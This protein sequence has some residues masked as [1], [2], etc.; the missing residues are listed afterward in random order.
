[1]ADCAACGLPLDPAARYC[2]HCGAGVTEAGGLR[3]YALPGTDDRDL[4]P[5]G[6]PA[7]GGPAQ[8]GRAQGGRAQ[9]GPAQGGRV[10]EAPREPDEPRGRRGLVMV[11][12][13]VVVA[14]VAVTAAT[15][16]VATRRH[17]RPAAVPGTAA[18]VGGG[19]AV[20]PTAAA[21][22]STGAPVLLADS[23]RRSPYAPNV[24]GLFRQYFEAINGRDYDAWLGTLS[25][26]RRPDPRQ[27][28]L[29]EYS[30]TADDEIRIVG[31]TARPDGSLLV[32]VSFRSRQDPR[33]APQDQPVDC[34]RW[35]IVYP[36]VNEDGRYKIAVVEFVNRTYRP[37][38]DR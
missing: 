4:P 33:Y 10:Q 2:R 8:G 31:I 21:P 6:G 11:V 29:E 23:L 35:Q 28:F 16:V 37:C 24:V 17:G 5:P 12:T 27:K 7:Q 20:T 22:T 14:V 38:T 9:G 18:P 32:A 25:R 19:Q 34:L 30:T 1:M 13:M 3:T 15:A 26:D 36:L